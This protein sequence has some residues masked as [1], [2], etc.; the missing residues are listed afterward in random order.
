MHPRCGTQSPK[1]AS[2]PVDL[3]GTLQGPSNLLLLNQLLEL[4]KFRIPPQG[5]Q[6]ETKFQWCCLQP[7]LQFQT[8][9]CSKRIPLAFLKRG[10]DL[11][12][13]F[14]ITANYRSRFFRTSLREKCYGCRANGLLMPNPSIDTKNTSL[15]EYSCSKIGT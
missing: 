5:V 9:S 12:V 2:A 1:S 15:L 3:T 10:K 6:R 13:S 7:L 8:L 14:I 4:R 11:G